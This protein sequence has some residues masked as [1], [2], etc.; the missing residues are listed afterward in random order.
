MFN[1]LT[2]LTLNGNAPGFLALRHFKPQSHV[3]Q[4]VP[5]A[6]LGDFHVFRHAV[7]QAE[8][9]P[10]DAPVQPVSTSSSLRF[11][12]GAVF[13]VAADGETAI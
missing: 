2:S 10:A 7:A 9:C 1:R 8:I 5:Q 12:I 6:G 13:T 11:T 3:Q 4:T